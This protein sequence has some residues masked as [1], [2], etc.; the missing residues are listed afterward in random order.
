MS[1]DLFVLYLVFDYYITL[2]FRDVELLLLIILGFISTINCFQLLVKIISN[3]VFCYES[4]QIL[5]DTYLINVP[6]FLLHG[7]KIGIWDCSRNSRWIIS[8]LL[9]ECLIWVLHK[10]LTVGRSTS[11]SNELSRNIFIYVSDLQEC[12]L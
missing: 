10:R 2:I 12:S 8:N 11:N 4:F 5:F 9:A 1:P 3:S 6:C 7:Y